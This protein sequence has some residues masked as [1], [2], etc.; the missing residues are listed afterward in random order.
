MGTEKV[1]PPLGEIAAGQ[2]LL[3]SKAATLNELAAKGF[4]V[5]PGFVVTAEAGERLGSRFAGELAEAADRTGPGPFAV[6]SS[7][8]AEDLPGASYAGLYETF[9]NVER[10]ELHDGIRRCLAS[11]AHGRVAAYKS[12]R[13][14]SGQPETGVPAMAALIQQM[15]QPV[16]AGVAFTAN[17]LTGN[18]SESIINAVQGLGESLVAGDAI[19]EEWIIRDQEATCTR[20]AG[21]LT[22]AQALEVA[23]LA[24]SVAAHAGVPQDIEWAIDADGVLFLLQARPM[25]ALPDPVDW[26]APGKGMWS[27][28][29]RLGEW[30]PDPMT[31]LF[32]DWL[33]PRIESGFL[34]G[35]HA[36]I[37][38]RVP[39]RY[40][41]VNGWYYNAP[42]IPSVRVLASVIRE[43]RGRAPWFLFNALSRVSHNPAAADRAVLHAL[44]LKWRTELLPAYRQLVER[45]GQDID[46]ASPARLVE[47][48]NT[49]CH[50][51]GIYSWSLA[52]L[53]GSAWKMESA[54]ARFWQKHLA[55]P[56]HGTTAGETGHQ[57]LLRGLSAP[58][59]TQAAH[60]VYSLDWYHPTAAE[61]PPAHQKQESPP[62][63]RSRSAAL[64][65]QRAA[66]EAAARD[67]LKE[68]PRVL[69]RFH[70]LLRVARLHGP[71]DWI[72][73]KPGGLAQRQRGV[74][75]P[76]TLPGLASAAHRRPVARG[77]AGGFVQCQEVDVSGIVDD[78][79]GDQVFAEPAGAAAQNRPPQ[80]EVER[81]FLTQQRVVLPPKVPSLAIPRAQDGRQ[82]P[83][84]S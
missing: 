27:R 46:S 34:D 13:G 71:G 15:V 67:A 64:K 84:V 49:V 21:I 51:A 58:T 25:T 55:G 24:H 29:F 45:A 17:P 35:M 80:T 42:P 22:A 6:R 16:A 44:E 37:G 18:R 31:P 28:N 8:A 20:N 43:G 54:L 26:A 53:G 10:G 40:A 61:A 30:L 78:F 72:S 47:L 77:G 83:S 2:A 48:I 19:G 14:T 33:L 57:A 60:A 66:S 32:E 75:A 52:I 1:F 41:S 81:L 73:N 63:H 68:Q 5:P 4:R 56:L 74:Q 12:A 3:G 82:E 36:D 23:G 50:H 76:L 62:V 79:L 38:A 7:A 65:A 70:A 39:F 11:A 9:L 69:A 59:S